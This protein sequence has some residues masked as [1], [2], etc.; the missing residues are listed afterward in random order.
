MKFRRLRPDTWDAYN[1]NHEEFNGL[2]IFQHV[3]KTAGSS[4]TAA[5]SSHAAPYINI[6]PDRNSPI[7][8]RK[9]YREMAATTSLDRDGR[10]MRSVSG[11]LWRADVDM[12]LER[13][14]HARLFTFV[15]DPVRR[16]ISDY[17]YSRTPA[18]AQWQE[19]ISAYPNLD[20]YI[21]DSPAVRNKTVFFLT[22]ERDGD[23]AEVIPWIMG[24]F[25]YIGLLEEMEMSHTILSRLLR[26]GKSKVEH[27]RSTE[28]LPQNA[29]VPT[30][31]Q[32]ARIRKMNDLDLALFRKVMVTHNRIREAGLFLL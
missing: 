31:A 8:I 9:Q 26:L 1:K 32:L 20:N 15:R 10:P 22:G 17:R 5:L 13:A 14:P 21:E 23:A 25:D 6:S 11:H 29:E 12:L 24:R 28:A 16:V 27:R 18:H 2:W 30:P 3:P 4:I 19:Q 7:S